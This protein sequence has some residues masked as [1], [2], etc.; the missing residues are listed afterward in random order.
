MELIKHD[1]GESTVTLTVKLVAGDYVPAVE[2]ELKKIRRN[3][4]VKGFRKG[5]VPMGL[6]K[7][8][9]GQSAMLEEVN[10]LVQQ[11]IN[12]GLKDET[13]NII[14][15]PIPCEAKQK[16][17]ELQIGNDLE[18]VYQAGFFGDFDLELNE[19]LILPYNEIVLENNSADKHIEYYRRYYGSNASVESIEDSDMVKAEIEINGEPTEFMFLM[20]V[21][22]AEQHVILTGAKVGDEIEIELRA[23][24]PNK[25]DLHNMLNIT[26][27]ML[28]ELPE[29]MSLKIIEITRRTPAELNQEF[30]DRVCGVDKVHDE[31]ELRTYFDNQDNSY[32]RSVSLKRLYKDARKILSDKIDLKLPADFLKDYF[33]IA[34]R[35]NEETEKFDIDAM[36]PELM[37]EMAWNHISN[38][39]L[40]KYQITV[41]EEDILQE[42]EKDLMYRLSIYGLTNINNATFEAML[43]KILSDEKQIEQIVNGVKE[44]KFAQLLSEKV[45]LDV[46]KMSA[47]EF[48]KEN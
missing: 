1:A 41:S 36:L 7:R 32:N 33:K 19:E 2:Q 5:M 22:P 8:M 37:E 18:F 14:G 30:F 15:E 29:K 47:A 31:N 25:A 27:E 3:A 42:A 39:L 6:I 17:L 20:S 48:Y 46:K 44:N 28:D 35:K 21:V 26:D 16:T 34:N 23:V 40:K 4:E 11:A 9:Y 24:F 43:N 10:K 45:T 13:R 38:K 12:D